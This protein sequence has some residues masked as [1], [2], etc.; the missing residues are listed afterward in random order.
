M[1]GMFNFLIGAIDISNNSSTGYDVYASGITLNGYALHPATI[2][3]LL[4][5]WIFSLLV[6]SAQ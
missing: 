3:K 6:A 1:D 2:A 5:R 4:Q